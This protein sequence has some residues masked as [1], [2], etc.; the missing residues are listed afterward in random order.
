MKK[1]ILYIF[2]TA[3]ALLPLQAAAQENDA[4]D[5]IAR[6]PLDNLIVRT[7]VKQSLFPEERVYLHFDNSAYYLGESM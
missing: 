7:A 6:N 4:E 3:F 2:A 5:K 1:S